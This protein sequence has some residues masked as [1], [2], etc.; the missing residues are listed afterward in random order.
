MVIII[1]IHFFILLS[2]YCLHMCH[3]HNSAINTLC[4][5][6]GE[7]YIATEELMV[8]FQPE[9]MRIPLSITLLDDSIPEPPEDFRLVLS[10]QVNTPDV[11]IGQDNAI[12]RL[13]DADSKYIHS[14]INF[15]LQFLFCATKKFSGKK[16]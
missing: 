9:D 10:R 1:I 16:I 12:V 15:M 6:A 11:I 4:T 13:E 7:D 5:H 14:H 3:C 8:I 2:V